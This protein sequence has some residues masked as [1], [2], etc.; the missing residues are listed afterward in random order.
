[1]L[2][3]AG[4]NFLCSGSR[5]PTLRLCVVNWMW[6]TLIPYHC[7]Q[8]EQDVSK[9]WDRRRKECERPSLFCLEDE[10]ET[11]ATLDTV[12]I[13]KCHHYNLMASLH[14]QEYNDSASYLW[15]NP[16][17]IHHHSWCKKANGAGLWFGLCWFMI[18]CDL[19]CGLMGLIV[20]LDGFRLIRFCF[21]AITQITKTKYGMLLAEQQLNHNI[22]VEKTR[23]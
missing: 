15:K 10:R 6:P 8:W 22:Q 23:N 9:V 7:I 11:C 17:M 4:A 18:S 21:S 20:F 2:T 16:N 14:F 19:L 12:Y 3:Q 13:T 1:M 5:C